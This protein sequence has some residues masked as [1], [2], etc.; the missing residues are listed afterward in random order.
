[1]V[2]KRSFRTIISTALETSSIMFDR[3][4][5]LPKENAMTQSTATSWVYGILAGLSI[6]FVVGEATQAPD[7]YRVQFNTDIDESVPIVI[8][9]NRSW[10]PI[11]ADH[12]YT[13]VNKKFYDNSALFRVVPKFVLQ[14]GISGNSSE[15]KKWLHSNIQDDP[16][17]ASN[18]RGTLAYADGGPNTRTTQIF[19]NYADNTRLDKMGFA[20]FAKVVSG[21]DVA[22]KAFNPTV[23]VFSSYSSKNVY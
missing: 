11:G 23:S 7:F 5:R 6:A 9:V 17:V 21:L 20:P 10:C 1:M 19:I 2:L 3:S 4:C 14:F 18:V 12:F 22:T 15:N 16:V 13:L 8:E